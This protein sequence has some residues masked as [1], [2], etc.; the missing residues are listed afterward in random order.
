ML[1][2]SNTILIYLLSFVHK[3]KV[4][5]KNGCEKTKKKANLLWPIVCC[6][7]YVDITGTYCDF[8]YSITITFRNNYIS[9]I[10]SCIKKFSS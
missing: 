3:Q 5:R 4:K 7:F 10:A 8:A 2:Y 6:I 9:S 1:K